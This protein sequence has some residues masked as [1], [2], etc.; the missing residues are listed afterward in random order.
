MV[1]QVPFPTTQNR[2]SHCPC[3]PN[4]I[5][6]LLNLVY[7]TRFALLLELTI[8]LK[9]LAAKDWVATLGLII[10]DLRRTFVDEF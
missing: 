4:S 9:D 7:I 1:N 2:K 10:P 6:N 5:S 8:A 3:N